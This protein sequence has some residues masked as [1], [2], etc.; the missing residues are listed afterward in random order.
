MRAIPG[1]A[2]AVV[3][4][5]GPSGLGAALAMAREGARPIVVDAGPVVGGLCVTRRRGDFGYDIGGHIPFVTDEPRLDYLRE[6]LGDR[7]RWVDR[8]VHCV[9]D[10]KLV[11]G[12]YL[13]QRP[14]VPLDAIAED[15]SAAGE[16]GSRFGAEFVDAVQRPYLEKVDGLP[17]EL[18]SADRVR[19]LLLEQAAPEGFW[20]P[21]GGIGELM[22]AM[23]AAITEAG[24]TVLVDAPAR[25]IDLT[26]GRARAV[27]IAVN[28][29]THRIETPDVVLAI[30][31]GLAARMATPDAPE[32]ATPSVEMR[33]VAIVYLDLA[34]TRITDEPWIQ[35][36]DPRVP[37]AR[38]FEPVNWSPEMAPE[39]RTVIGLECYCAPTADDPV[40]S[41]DDAQLAGACAD[42][43]GGALGWVD[44]T[45][46]RSATTVE[47]I[48]IQNAYPSP[49]LAQVPAI[50]APATWLATQSGIHQ[51][52]GSAVI[53]A[54]EAGEG[55]AETILAGRAGSLAG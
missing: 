13:D 26:G 55:T 43:L 29:V 17:L 37:F 32:W 44:A 4:G 20:F 8:P 16:L 31:A 36:D 54:I 2:D 50:S 21:L 33:A 15:G 24:G 18:I 40:W 41:L 53:D 11:R 23:S 28:G 45:T 19:R 25:H 47:V 9:R 5:A 22:D 49:A 35:V 30:P 1:N 51:A 42:A 7:L 34:R 27:E 14:T 6:L 39:D 52:R 38:A 48:R 10:G 12:R 46:A 3:V